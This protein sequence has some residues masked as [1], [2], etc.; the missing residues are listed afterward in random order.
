MMAAEPPKSLH[1]ILTDTALRTEVGGPD[2]MRRQLEHLIFLIDHRPKITIQVLAATAPHNPAPGG[3]LYLLH[4][5]EAL[6]PI[7]FLPVT[8][9]PGTYF[10]EPVDTARLA[11]ALD[12]LAELAASPDDSRSLIADLVTRD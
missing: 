2:T 3:G 4:L 12:R 7:G 6:P 9:G 5:G 8:Y 10:D 1:F 11:R